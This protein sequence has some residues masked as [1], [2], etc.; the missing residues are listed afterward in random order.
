MIEGTETLIW[1]IFIR[2]TRKIDNALKSITQE[3]VV[4]AND[5]Q[6][7]TKLAI[8]TAMNWPNVIHAEVDPEGKRNSLFPWP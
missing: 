3:I 7:A 1:V 6:E 2:I 4:P 8:E 5:S